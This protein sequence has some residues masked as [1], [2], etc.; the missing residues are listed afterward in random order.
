[1]LMR[2]NQRQK[3]QWLSNFIY[4]HFKSVL[5]LYPV[6]E[7][8]QKGFLDV[9]R[10][11][12]GDLRLRCA[13]GVQLSHHGHENDQLFIVGA[14]FHHQKRQK[15]ARAHRGAGRVRLHRH[16][17]NDV[18]LPLLHAIHVRAEL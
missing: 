14:V 2:Q 5:L 10:Q 3:L 13:A 4:S 17:Q 11:G 18:V 9:N 1:M 16:H 12:L 15:L 8:F 7:R 6:F